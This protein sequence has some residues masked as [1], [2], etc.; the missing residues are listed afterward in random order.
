MRTSKVHRSRKKVKAE[1]IASRRAKRRAKHLKSLLFLGRPGRDVSYRTPYGLM[2]QGQSEDVLTSGYM[3]KFRGEVDLIFT[4]PPFPLNRKKKYGNFQGEEYIDWLCKFGPIFKSLLSEAGSIVLELGNSWVKGS[5]TMSTLATRALLTFLDRNKL[6]LCQ[7]FIWNNPAK[8]PTPAQWV[9]VN[10]VR[11]KDSFTKIWWMS[12]SATPEADNRR[13]L[14]E[15]SD[16]MKHLLKTGSYN[17][18]TRASEHT[19]GDKSFLVDH[20]GAIS[21]SV[22]THGNTRSNDKY[23]IFCKKNGLTPHPARMPKALAEFF[24]KFLT[25]KGGLVLD[26]FGGSNTTGATAEELGR[27]WIT[28]E[29]TD[30]YI[31]SSVS[32]FD[33]TK[34]RSG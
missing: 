8:L 3:S 19:I 14:T 28:V 24:I 33:Y 26:P 22:L 21:G 9:T 6:H 30:E 12:P 25:R 7:E 10:R 23:Q 1:S 31:K 2:M 32:R 29:P 17:A 16:S 34:R 27:H 11:V 4:S 15:Y 13:V 20:G 18:G 5:P